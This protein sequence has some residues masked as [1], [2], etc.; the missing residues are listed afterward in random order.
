M[1]VVAEKVERFVVGKNPI[2]IDAIA[3]AR[4]EYKAIYQHE[5]EIIRMESS[6]YQ[7]IM[8]QIPPYQISFTHIMGLEI[9]HDEQLKEGEW[10]VGQSSEIL[11]IRQD[12][13][14][15]EGS[16]MQPSDLDTK[17]ESR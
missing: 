15:G 6:A 17:K 1:S 3:M 5:P 11:T 9:Q 14:R 4:Y 8:G 10:R 7:F 2:S 13:A 12:Y 16:D